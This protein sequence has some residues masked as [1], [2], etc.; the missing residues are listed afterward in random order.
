MIL[1]K[2]KRRMDSG[3][4]NVMG[5]VTEIEHDSDYEDSMEHDAL[6]GPKTDM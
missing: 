4:E 5:L 3:N 1:K 6:H 2:K